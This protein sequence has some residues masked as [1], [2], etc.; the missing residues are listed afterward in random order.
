MYSGNFGH[1]KMTFCV[2][3]CALGC[4]ILNQLGWARVLCRIHMQQ[5]I[6]T[7]IIDHHGGS[8]WSGTMTISC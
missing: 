1:T 5:G 6:E 8:S 4:A 7:A 2:F 3:G